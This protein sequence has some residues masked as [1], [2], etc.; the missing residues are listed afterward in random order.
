ML[1]KPIGDVLEWRQEDFNAYGY[2]INVNR[3]FSVVEAHFPATIA[4]INECLAKP[5]SAQAIK[6]ICD[7][8][9]TEDEEGTTYG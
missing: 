5:A 3:S 6:L 8:Y 1:D 2:A 7:G 9:G 4:Y